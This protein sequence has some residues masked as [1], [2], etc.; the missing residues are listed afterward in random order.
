MRSLARSVCARRADRRLPAVTATMRPM[1]VRRLYPD[2]AELP[3]EDA[4]ATLDLAALAPADRPYLVLNM[5]ETLD[6][7]ITIGG[8][9]GAIGNDADRELFHGLRV[10]ADAVMAGAGTVRT[11]RYGRLV[12]VPRRRE[13]RA[14]AGLRP[15]PIAIVVSAT[16][17][18]SPELPL[19][20]DP[21]SHVVIL[22]AADRSLD[23]V[24]ADVDYLRAT[25]RARPG[26][27]SALRLRPLLERLRAE[28]GVRS[29]V[30]EG[31]P[32]LNE[33]LL[34]EGVVDEL[35]LS[36]SPKLAAGGGPPLVAGDELSP[37]LELDLVWVLEAEGHLFMRYRVASA[38]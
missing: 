1:N 31:G 29:I 6:G 9:S 20:Q 26:S 37:P 8:R 13:R 30:C 19:L 23:G 33:T 4:T 16:L 11:E 22:T 18:L 28:H 15:H 14:A 21:D 35:F 10:A 38:G 7:R 34:R 3:A 27:P 5:V 17:A 32:R 2:P 36:L 24:A 25:A 12:R